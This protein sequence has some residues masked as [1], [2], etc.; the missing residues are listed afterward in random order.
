MQLSKARVDRFQK[1]FVLMI[2]LK[3]NI[4]I[5]ICKMWFGNKQQW[6]EV[7][8]QFIDLLDVYYV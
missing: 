7:D 4:Y 6:D 2:S 3:L 5:N 8:R 1:E